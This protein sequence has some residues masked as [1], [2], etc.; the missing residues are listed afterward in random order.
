VG[1]Q[2]EIDWN[3]LRYF[4]AAARAKTL[5]GAARALDV[6]HSTIGRRLTALEQAMGAPL[7]TRGPEGLLLTAAGGKV[8]PLVE[9]IERA[10]LAA[11][12][13]VT[14]DRTRVRLATPSGFSRVLAPHL[15][16]FH[17]RHPGV[18]IELL[19]SSRMVDL[20]KG[21][22]DVAI[23]QGPSEDEE[24]ITR[25]IGEVPWSLFGSDPYLIRRPA[26]SDPRRL[27]GHDLLG[28]EG[29]LSGV[30]GARWIEEHG[31]GAN[32]IMRCR[33]LSDMLAG[34]VAGLG[35]A[36]LP[37]TAAGLEPSLRRLTGEMLGSSTLWIVYRKEVRV[38][39]PV[40]AVIE[41]VT[42][43]MRQHLHGVCGSS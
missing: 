24:L 38:A 11:R 40:L 32:V 35:L 10:V 26:P 41:L 29:R 17:A 34:C 39:E 16:A 28:F 14:A 36:V 12:E 7:V 25:R 8:V 20:K 13:I 22:A 4:L 33:E 2:N 18:T 1:K 3:D 30:P 19:G 42:E 23:R 15:S 27:A 6:E 9:E 21:E 43:V 37:C 31:E 5:A